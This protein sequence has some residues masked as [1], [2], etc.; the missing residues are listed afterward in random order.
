MTS[1]K[2]RS[3]LSSL[4]FGWDVGS[5]ERQDFLVLFLFCNDESSHCNRVIVNTDGV[6]APCQALYESFT[7][8][9]IDITQ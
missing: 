9:I 4:I 6:L 5:A 1:G 7:H 3:S 2:T 8:L